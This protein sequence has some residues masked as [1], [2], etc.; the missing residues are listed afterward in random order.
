MNTECLVPDSSGTLFTY[1]G[2]TER[3]FSDRVYE[4]Y[5]YDLDCDSCLSKEHLR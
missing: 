3:A 4:W 1:F 2:K 5:G